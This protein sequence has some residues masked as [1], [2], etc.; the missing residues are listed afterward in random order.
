MSIEVEPGQI[1]LFLFSS[2]IDSTSEDP[3]ASA[4][5]LGKRLETARNARYL[6][7]LA[8]LGE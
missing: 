5:S 4:D 2:F 3:A 1:T 6:T 8:H 7:V